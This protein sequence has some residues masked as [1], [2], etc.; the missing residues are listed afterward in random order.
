MT[1]PVL[2][3]R[4]PRTLIATAWTGASALTAGVS[5]HA[6]LAQHQLAIACTGIP[7][8]GIVTIWIRPIGSGVF[9]SVGT[10]D[11]SINGT[12][13][14]L[15]SGIF[16]AIK[17]TV[18]PAFSG[19]TAAAQLDSQNED[20]LFEGPAGAPGS[21]GTPGPTGPAGATGPAGPSG[22]STTYWPPLP[23]GNYHIGGAVTSL[24]QTNVATDGNVSNTMVLI[25]FTVP[26]NCSVTTIGFVVTTAV[27]SN[28]AEVGIYADSSGAPGSL[29]ASSG[30]ISTSTAG[31]MSAAVSLSLTAGTPYWFAVATPS[32]T[33]LFMGLSSAVGQALG[34]TPAL[35][36][37]LATT[38]L[39]QTL[40]SGW[41]VLP[42]TAAPSSNAAQAVPAIYFNG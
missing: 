39:K 12:G 24:L 27:A 3:R 20:F 35:T 19:I 7:A 11:L 28:V 37:T 40:T 34:F 41:T 1:D 9:V 16:D 2:R 29:L 8:S 26:R 32:T 5:D 23:S 13:R 38:C 6:G 10:I 31:F 21:A 30:Q 42:A 4:V 17:L 36:N 25:P 15:F 33:G 14:L 18:S 22:P